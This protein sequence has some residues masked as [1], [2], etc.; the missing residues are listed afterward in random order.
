M[1][2]MIDT[3][4]NDKAIAQRE[5]MSSF[6]KRPLFLKQKLQ[7]FFEGNSFEGKLIKFLNAG[8]RAPVESVSL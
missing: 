3:A 8:L 2:G 1:A 6:L 4:A 5:A 7:S